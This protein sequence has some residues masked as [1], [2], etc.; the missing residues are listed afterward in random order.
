M[1]IQQISKEYIARDPDRCNGKPCIVGTRISVV[2]IAEMYLEMG[3]SLEEIATKYDLS[4]AA[5]HGA[6]AYYYDHKEEIDRHNFETDKII[7]Q[8]KRN[9]PPSKFQS[10]W[11]EMIGEK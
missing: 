6:M 8:M 10:R 2:A 4:L 11:R 3:Q 7:E 5:V 9:S 1:P